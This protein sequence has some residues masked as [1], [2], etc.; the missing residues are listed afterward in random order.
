MNTERYSRQ[1]ILPEI[2]MSGQERIIASKVLV[3]GAGGLGC[4]VIQ[5][6][7]AAGV[8]TIGIVDHDIVEESNLPRQPLFSTEDIGKYKAEQAGR[9]IVELNPDCNVFT[10]RIKLTK[11]NSEGIISEYNVIADCSDNFPTRYMINDACKAQNRPWVMGAIEGWTG[12]IAVFNYQ[13]GPAYRDIFPDSDPETKNCNTIGV[14]PTLPAVIGSYMANEILKMI[15]NT[16]A[17]LSG[18]MMIVDLWHNSTQ[19]LNVKKPEPE[20]SEKK[21]IE[22]GWDEAR[23]GGYEIIDIRTAEDILVPILFK[24]IPYY[25]LGVE[26][27][28]TG[29]KYVLVC[30]SGLKSKILAKK[31][32]REN[33]ELQIFSVRGG[34]LS[35]NKNQWQ[36]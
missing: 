5:Y 34:Y 15:L 7:A 22:I 25:E 27:L 4:P 31:L 26:R 36:T 8:G 19:Y 9:K 29:K 6:L 11:D 3:I 2:G 12:Q 28:T 10:Y 21:D 35:F 1:I 24:N 30:E 33:K 14:S 13:N 20:S 32:R 18:R 17:T 23:S 16:D